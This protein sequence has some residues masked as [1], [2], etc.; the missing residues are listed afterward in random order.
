LVEHSRLVLA[1]ERVSQFIGQRTLWSIHD[2]Q[3]AAGFVNTDR[4]SEPEMPFGP[5]LGVY[6]LVDADAVDRLLETL[7]SGPTTAPSPQTP[8][9]SHHPGPTTP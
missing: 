9:P 8:C 6:R 1:L 5:E 7:V 3:W 4:T 2:V